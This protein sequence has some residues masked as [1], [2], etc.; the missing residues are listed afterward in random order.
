MKSLIL[1]VAL[2]HAVFI[3]HSAEL[4]NKELKISATVD[5]NI[6]TDGSS[7]SLTADASISFGKSNTKGEDDDE[8]YDGSDNAG[9]DE[10]KYKLTKKLVNSCQY[11]K[12]YKDKTNYE[13]CGCKYYESE[14][15]N[16]EYKG[17]NSDED[18]CG[19]QDNEDNEDEEEEEEE[20]ESEE[21][22]SSE[23][24]KKYKYS[25]YN[26]DNSNDSDNSDD[27]EDSD[28]SEEP[29]PPTDPRPF[30]S[31]LGTSDG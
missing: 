8:E 13:D 22:E 15:D 25:K 23:E 24:I 26:D 31:G 5:K 28:D 16:N 17:Y 7:S 11:S 29:P 27:S 19:C 9:N 10:Y 21:F 1:F 6:P 30:L 14:E 4:P 12:N 18:T 3:I 20:Y 2:A